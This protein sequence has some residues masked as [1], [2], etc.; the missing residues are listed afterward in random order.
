MLEE[1]GLTPVWRLR[2]RR[3]AAAVE[4]TVVEAPRQQQ[5]AGSR[6]ECT[7]A[8]VTQSRSHPSP[9][10]ATA[11][12]RSCA[13]TGRRSRQRVAGCTDCPLHEKRKK[14]VFGVGDENADWLFVGEGPGRG[15]R[16]AGRAVRRAGRAGC[17]TTCCAAI[18]LKRGEDVYIANMRQ[19]PPAG[20]PQSRAGRGARMRAVPAPPDRADPA[21]ADRRARQGRG[22][23]P[24][25]DAT[26]ASPAC[27]ARCTDYRGT[28]LIVTYHPAY[29][30]R[31]LPDKAKAWEDL[32]FAVRDD[33]GLAKRA[34]APHITSVIRDW[35]QGAH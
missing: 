3:E 10:T 8:P 23:E 25:R 1:M 30:L 12:R 7:A 9:R 4:A 13:W 22:G 17:S 18:G 16:R 32:C 21:E 26:P 15:G 29:L 6:H 35:R 19:M 31:N 2:D 33:A 14:T 24:A 27:A 20:Q 34:A 11:A 5:Q 28:P